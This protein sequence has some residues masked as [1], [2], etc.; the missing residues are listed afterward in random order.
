MGN[1]KNVRL[2]RVVGMAQ[3]TPMSILT[4]FTFPSI[5]TRPYLFGSSLKTVFVFLE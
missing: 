2:V 4:K 1:V 3:L 5:L